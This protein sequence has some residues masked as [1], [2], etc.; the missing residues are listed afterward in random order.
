VLFKAARPTLLNGIEDIIG[1]SDLADRAIL[2]TLGPIGEEQRRSETELWREFELARPAIL[3]LPINLCHREYHPFQLWRLTQSWRT[4]LVHR[5]CARTNRPP[6][7]A[8][9]P[10]PTSTISDPLPL[11]P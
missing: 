3:A 6:L 7:A 2:L 1:R 8:T 11:S 5:Q 4:A 10:A 9:E